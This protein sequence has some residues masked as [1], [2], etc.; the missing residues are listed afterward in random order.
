MGLCVGPIC[1]SPA[2]CLV[3]LLMVFQWDLYGYVCTV[4]QMHTIWF[5]LVVYYMGP[6]TNI[7][8]T[9][10]VYNLLLQLKRIGT[11]AITTCMM[12]VVEL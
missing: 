5:P 10:Y 4:A 3:R 8:P 2:G 11:V 1:D 12:L 6:S 9:F 7:P